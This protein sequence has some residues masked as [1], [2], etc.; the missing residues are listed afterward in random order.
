MTSTA[1]TSQSD[2]YGN[3]K[4]YDEDKDADYDE[5]DYSAFMTTM[6]KR[7]YYYNDDTHAVMIVDEAHTDANLMT[8]TRWTDYC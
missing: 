7:M 4:Q 8:R 1:A 2:V 3:H 6:S 5:F